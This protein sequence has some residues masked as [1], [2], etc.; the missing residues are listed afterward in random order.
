MAFSSGSYELIILPY[1]ETA[2]Y[3]LCSAYT[4]YAI[5]Y[6]LYAIRYT[7]HGVRGVAWRGVLLIDVDVVALC[8][9]EKWFTCFLC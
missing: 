6:T 9:Y 3:L 2:E 8:V 7:L 4:L 5:R 1:P